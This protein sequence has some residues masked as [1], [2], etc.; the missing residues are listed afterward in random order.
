MISSNICMEKVTVEHVI[1]RSSNTFAVVRETLE[2]LVPRL[3]DGF[4]FVSCFGKAP[5]AKL[6]LSM[7]GRFRPSDS[8]ATRASILLLGSSMKIWRLS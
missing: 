2:A 8:L 6:H 7:I 5:R 3:D 4:P 1:I